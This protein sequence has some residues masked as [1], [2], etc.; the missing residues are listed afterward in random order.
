MKIA[1]MHMWFRQYAQQMGMQNVRAI[2]PEQIDTLINTSIQDIIDEVITKNVGLTNDRIISDNSKLASINALRS[3]YRVKTL[4]CD[5]REPNIELGLNTH[6]SDY[7][8]IPLEFTSLSATLP[9][10]R[11]I[12]DF[13]VN[14]DLGSGKIS[15]WFPIRIVNDSNLADILNDWVLAPRVRTPIMVIYADASNSESGEDMAST[16]GST[17]DIYFGEN[18]PI[19]DVASAIT[20]H[21]IRMSYIKV[22]NKVK[23]LSDIGSDNINS[24]LPEQLHIPML[25]HAVDLYRASISGNLFVT[26]DQNRD[27]QREMVRNEARPDNDGY[28]S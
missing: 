8:N 5:G 25:K 10:Y 12:V 9:D 11:Y 24:D 17:F 2:L 3:L 16:E 1:E 13:A 21:E 26:Q 7:A 22:P 14:Y 6:P 20:I 28:Q 23:Y 18:E 27:Q 19:E 4:T 15:R